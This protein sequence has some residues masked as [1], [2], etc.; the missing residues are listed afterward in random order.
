MHGDGHHGPITSHDPIRYGT[1]QYRTT[2]A[3]FRLHDMARWHVQFQLKVFFFFFGFSSP[4]H[5]QCRC[6][7]QWNYH[8]MCDPAALRQWLRQ[9]GQRQ[10]YCSLE[11]VWFRG[12]L[13]VS[14]SVLSLC[15][16]AVCNCQSPDSEP[17][18][19]LNHLLHCKYPV[20]NPSRFRILLLYLNPLNGTSEA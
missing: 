7:L 11:G 3:T 2:A 8:M 6:G 15:R 13:G 5:W 4:C 12:P 18:F 20:V 16:F 14:V 17:D 19:H 9:W 1:V 10:V